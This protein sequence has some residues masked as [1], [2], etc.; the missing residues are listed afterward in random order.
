MQLTT[1]DKE[2]NGIER[3]DV[4]EGVA[5]SEKEWINRQ[6]TMKVVDRVWAP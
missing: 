5:V 1:L 3:C 4:K 6:D 2:R